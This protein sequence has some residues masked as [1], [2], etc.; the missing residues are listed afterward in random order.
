MLQMKHL[1]IKNILDQKLRNVRSI[2]R[3]ADDDSFMYAIMMAQ[4]ALCAPATPAEDGLDKFAFEIASIQPAKQLVEIKD[5][6]LSSR[7]MLSPRDRLASSE[8]RTT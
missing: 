2:E 7:Q 5:F 8:A 4:N 1:V 6:T 3:T